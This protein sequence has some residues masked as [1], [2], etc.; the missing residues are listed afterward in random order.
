MPRVHGKLASFWSEDR[1]LTVFLIALV[2]VAFVIGPLGFVGRLGAVVLALSSTFLLITG[3]L[4]VVRGRRAAL[5]ASLL[6]L[7]SLAVGWLVVWRP[8]LVLHVVNDVLLVVYLAILAAVVFARV[9]RGGTITVH[10]IVGAVAAYILLGIIWTQLYELIATLQPAAF[11]YDAGTALTRQVLL[12]YSFV[13]MTTVGYGDIV[14]VHPV[15]R[16]LAT[17]EALIGQLYPAILIARLVSLEIATRRS[18]GPQF[19][20]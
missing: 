4:T 20:P 15:A 11:R 12:Y 3:V 6:A 9:F 5:G 17:L 19:R 8:S 2:L 1:A 13:T 14:P 7:G 10:R 16:S 18:P